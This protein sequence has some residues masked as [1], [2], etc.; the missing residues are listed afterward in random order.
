LPPASTG[1]ATPSGAEK[2]SQRAPKAGG[3][4]GRPQFSV[5]ICEGLA[6]SLR[7]IS[8][9]LDDSPNVERSSLK[10]PFATTFPSLM[11][12]AWEQILAT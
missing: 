2:Q 11:M 10:D 7:K 6:V 8:S 9:K 3:A 4:Y 5:H 1:G 12:T